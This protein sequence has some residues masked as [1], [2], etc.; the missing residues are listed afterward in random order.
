[1][2]KYE[3]EFSEILLKPFQIVN[4]SIFNLFS[5]FCN[6][7]C[8]K[9]NNTVSRKELWILGYISFLKYLNL[10]RTFIEI[11]IRPFYCSVLLGVCFDKIIEVQQQLVHSH[12]IAE[13][14]TASHIFKYYLIYTNVL[15]FSWYKWQ[16]KVVVSS[17]TSGKI[18]G[19]PIDFRFKIY[20]SFCTN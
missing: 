5:R 2:V 6:S 11:F 4:I 15:L 12:D 20:Y 19:E 14:A 16:K 13:M 17:K 3:N 10:C 7:A 9:N 18:I 8:T 1:M